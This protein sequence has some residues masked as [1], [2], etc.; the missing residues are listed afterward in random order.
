MVQ[1]RPRTTAEY[2]T[3]LMVD[4]RFY[5]LSGQGEWWALTE[6][7][8]RGWRKLL[9]KIKDAGRI[10]AFTRMMNAV[11]KAPASVAD[12]AGVR[13][14]LRREALMIMVALDQMGRRIRMQA[15]EIER[16]AVAC[17]RG[18]PPPD[19]DWTPDELRRRAASVHFE[20]DAIADVSAAFFLA[21]RI[22]LDGIPATSHSLSQGA[23]AD[24]EPAAPST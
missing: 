14:L 15:Q 11:Y 12:A 21:N 17:E 8:R 20:A 1:W 3:A 16:E 5:V 24:R 9:V 23:A 22:T 10:G 7:D 2:T 4:G 19:G 13:T 18:K 6:P